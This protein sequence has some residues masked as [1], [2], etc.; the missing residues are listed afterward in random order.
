MHLVPCNRFLKVYGILTL[1]HLQENKIMKLKEFDKPYV[2]LM[3]VM[4]SHIK[5]LTSLK[6]LSVNK[7]F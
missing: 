2:P 6:S 1:Q 5:V 7:P 4:E 3:D